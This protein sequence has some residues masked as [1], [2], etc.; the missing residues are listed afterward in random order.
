MT[1]VSHPFFRLSG[2]FDPD[3]ITKL[4]DIQPSAV[5]RIG[6]PG[7]PDALGPRVGAEWIWQPVDDDSDHVADQLAYLAGSLSLKCK[8]V[9]DLSQ[10]FWGTFHVYNQFNH[11]WFLPPEALRLIANL[12]V[13]IQCE[14]VRVAQEEE[15][16]NGGN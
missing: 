12:H 7:P 14:N 11:D 8:E 1:R 9:A 10:R 2:K 16:K 15:I 13:S 4:L 3:E 5:S 6:D